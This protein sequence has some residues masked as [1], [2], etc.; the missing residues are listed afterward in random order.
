MK[1]K[2]HAAAR[3]AYCGIECS[4]G[5]ARDTD[6]VARSLRAS[7]GQGGLAGREGWAGKGR[8]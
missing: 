8:S 5:S 2:L 3:A 1:S 4:I 6:V 7:G